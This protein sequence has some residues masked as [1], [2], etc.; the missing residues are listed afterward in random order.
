MKYED[1]N[2]HDKWCPVVFVLSKT[3][4]AATET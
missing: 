2:S 1:K 4:W 3:F